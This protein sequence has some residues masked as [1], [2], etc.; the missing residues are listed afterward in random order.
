MEQLFSEQCC[1]KY[2]RETIGN[3][4]LKCVNRLFSNYI[5]PKQFT[6]NLIF[7]MEKMKHIIWITWEHHIRNISL[8]DRLDAKLYEL[9]LPKNRFFRYLKAIYLTTKILWKNKKNIIITQNPSL[10]LSLQATL[11][12]PFFCYKLIVDAHNAGIFP[13]ENRSRTLTLIANYIIR[14][15]D[16]VIITNQALAN[17][18]ATIGG[19]GVILPDPLPKLFS[20]KNDLRKK[21]I[22][23]YILFVCTWAEDEPYFEVF[24]AASCMPEVDIYVSGN[25]K[26]R[27]KLYNQELPSNIKLTGFLPDS[28]YRSLLSNAHIVIDLT[29]RDDCLV[30][31]AYEAVAAE[32]PFILSD[33]KALKAYFSMGGMHVDNSA[34]AIASAT[35]AILKDYD[36]YINEVTNFNRLL[37]AHWLELFQNAKI[38]INNRC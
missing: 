2:L 13:R 8:C 18:V 32:R 28:E 16:L 36:F 5:T 21:N 31:G 38:E 22:R 29:T 19:R 35:K 10:I 6:Q 12:K 15:A 20:A 33:S 11:L 1:D 23:P 30:C 9:A 25:S 26:G 7:L 27:E 17:R 3:N 14:N 24:N 34:T 4:G 37:E